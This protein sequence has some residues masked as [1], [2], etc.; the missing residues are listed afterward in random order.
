MAMSFAVL[1]ARV[2]GMAIEEPDVVG[3]SFPNFWDVLE[4]MLGPQSVRAV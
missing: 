3:K 1:G 2:A 4:E